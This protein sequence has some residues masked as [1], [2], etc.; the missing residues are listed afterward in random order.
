MVRVNPNWLES[1]N[2]RILST[3]VCIIDSIEK[4]PEQKPD[5]IIIDY[6]ESYYKSRKQPKHSFS[7]ALLERV[8]NDNILRIIKVNE[9]YLENVNQFTLDKLVIF[10]IDLFIDNYHKYQDTIVVN[11]EDYIKIGFQ[12][13][14]SALNH[15]KTSPKSMI[16]LEKWFLIQLNEDWKLIKPIWNDFKMEAFTTINFILK[17][18]DIID[19]DPFINILNAYLRENETFDLYSNYRL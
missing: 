1:I 15:L 10:F 3:L 6:V 14:I 19:E 4:S 17:M 13:L 7:D 2:E 8:K 11:D 16:K 5:K 9:R 18:F 12:P